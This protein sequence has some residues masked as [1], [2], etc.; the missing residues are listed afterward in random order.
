MWGRAK[1]GGCGKEDPACGGSSCP[2]AAMFPCG[3]VKQEGLMGRG[4]PLPRAGVDLSFGS[5]G[6][7][8]TSV[9]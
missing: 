4:H 8:V 2:L 5:T 3:A 6:T 9:G 1:G 7:L